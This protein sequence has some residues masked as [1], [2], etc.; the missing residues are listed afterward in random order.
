M[1]R[2]LVVVFISGRVFAL[3]RRRGIATVMVEIIYCANVLREEK[4]QCPVKCDSNLFVQAGQ[5][6]QVNGPP[7]PPREEAREIETE[8]ACHAR[9]TTD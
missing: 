5:L 3:A 8:N 6:A 4:I 7:Q 2:G 1:R 9:P